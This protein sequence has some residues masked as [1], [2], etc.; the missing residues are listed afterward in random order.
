MNLELLIVV[1]THTSLA[2]GRSVIQSFSILAKRKNAENQVISAF[3][4]ISPFSF[5]TPERLWGFMLCNDN[6]SVGITFLKAYILDTR[7]NFIV[8]RH[9]SSDSAK[10]VIFTDVHEF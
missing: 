7:Q 1:T 3:L 10:V 2:A 4:G 8:L 6:Q 9:F 5:V